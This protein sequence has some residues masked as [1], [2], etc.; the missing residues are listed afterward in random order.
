MSDWFDIGAK[1][2]E[3]FPVLHE[4]W[5]DVCARS[6]FLPDDHVLGELRRLLRSSILLGQ[7]AIY[8][9]LCVTRYSRTEA[10]NT[11]EDY[12]RYY[13]YDFIGRVKSSSD[14]FALLVNH[15]YKLG[16]DESKC[17]LERGPI[18]HRLD[19]DEVNRDL[20]ALINQARDQWLLPFYDMRNFVVHR[21]G[22][23]FVVG[24]IDA[25]SLINI[26]LGE[27]L[28]IPKER[29]TIE[30]FLASIGAAASKTCILDPGF[31][32][33]NLWDKWKHL[34]NAIMLSIRDEICHFVK[35]NM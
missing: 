29:R 1:C 10:S 8:S 20:A 33:E 27:M 22:L 7:H 18:V 34:A 35:V 21:S 32:C 11:Y 16:V 3:S 25:G 13:I 4:I 19:A 6:G 14:I 24:G 28:R 23:R 12:V 26:Q 30:R 17:A 2:K 9:S 15:V 31:F 5:N